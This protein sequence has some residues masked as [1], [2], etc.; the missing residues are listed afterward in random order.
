MESRLVAF[1]AFATGA[2]T[3]TPVRMYNCTIARTADGDYDL[4]IGQ[5]GVDVSLMI[6]ASNARAGAAAG[7]GTARIVNVTSTSDTVKRIQIR[8]DA[9]VFAIAEAV[10]IEIKKMPPLP[11]P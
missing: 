7:A 10:H 11:T 8:D 6:V 4:T 3:V 1:A 9:G 5:G 2:G